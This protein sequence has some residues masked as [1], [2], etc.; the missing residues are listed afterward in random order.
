MDTNTDS[1]QDS[2]L[3]PLPAQE[4]E[5]PPARRPRNMAARAGLIG[6]LLALLIVLGIY[7]YGQYMFAPTGKTAEVRIPK[8]AG[9]SDVGQLLQDAGV[10]RSGQLFGL[11][12]RFTGRDT[13]LR[14][15][16]YRIEGRGIVEVAKSLTD[17]Q[18]VQLTTEVAFP[19]G[20]RAD[21]MA[22]RL[23]QSGFNGVEFLK[24]IR[25][26]LAELRPKEASGPSLEGFLF[27]ATYSFPRD[28][29]TS[30]L[31]KTMT[32][33]MAQEFKPDYQGTLGKLKLSI[34]DWVVL[35]SIVQAEAA[36]AEEMPVIAGIFL[37]RLEL[38]Q[39]LQSDPTVAYALSKD[40]PQLDRGAGDFE[41]DSP[42]NTYKYAGLPPGAIGNPGSAALQSILRPKRTNAKGQKLYYFLH[43]QGK[44]FVNVDFNGHLRDTARYR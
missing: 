8:G 44:I 14:S 2:S 18:A 17:K 29:T 40:L 10:V 42:Y 25:Q 26:P 16:Y 21:Q 6:F 19:E 27:P 13:D 20:W 43:A 3:P 38:G 32:A 23:S 5:I 1:T 4:S 22:A 11:Y 9:A 12:L 41:V 28:A 35:A 34:H 37:N 31:V 33:R 15:G 30:D 24:L 36:N 7:F 39:G